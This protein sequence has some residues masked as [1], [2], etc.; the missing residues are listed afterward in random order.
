M[1]TFNDLLAHDELKAYIKEQGF[2]HPTPVQTKGIPVLAKKQSLSLLGKTGTGKTLSYALPIVQNV[3]NDE[4]SGIETKPGHPKA[5]IILPTKELTSQVFQ[6]FKDISHFSKLRV[7]KLLGGE[8]GQKSRELSSQNF[9]ILVTGPGRL[10]AMVEKKEI[11]LADTRYIILDE[12]DTLL[13][14]GFFKEIKKLWGFCEWEGTTVGLISA[15]MPNDF[16]RFKDE[17][18]ETI[19]FK[20]LEVGGHALKQ[21]I[22]TFNIDLNFKEKNK[23]T[24]LFLEKQPAGSG[25]IF[26]NRKETTDE[27][28]KFLK[29][30]FPSKRFYILH[31]EMDAKERATSFKKFKEKGGVMVCTDIA[32]RGIDIPALGWV[33]NYDL[34]F[35]AVF[36]IHRSGR[37]G[38]GG[39]KGS[40]FNFVTSRDFNLIA[41][42]NTSIKE[43]SLL[44]L[45]TINTKLQRTLTKKKEQKKDN[46]PVKKARE[47]RPQVGRRKTPR[48]KKSK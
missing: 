7:R 42:I 40:V 27:V 12:A 2:A 18:F 43:Q 30:E 41:R 21:E 24:K 6:V 47:K 44:K 15:T 1:A 39:R 5:V 36:Y 46:T 26:C 19:D 29:E 10:A 3:K 20:M 32:A 35:E 8:K 13:D 16:D 9:E 45:T 38:R 22:E 14:M 48:Y 23:M 34:P 17:V 25:M 31:G 28:F 37:V 4:Q 33:L 11:S